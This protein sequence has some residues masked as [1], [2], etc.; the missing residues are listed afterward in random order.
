MRYQNRSHLNS[1]TSYK[2]LSFQ[3][4]IPAES[5]EIKHEYGRGSAFG[6]SNYLRT[7]DCLGV[8]H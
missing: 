1:N 7:V 2:M 6:G 8:R 4:M 5:F 3:P